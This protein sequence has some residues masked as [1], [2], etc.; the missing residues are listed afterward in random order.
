MWCGHGRQ[1]HLGLGCCMGYSMI[2]GIRGAN[3]CCFRGAFEMARPGPA[4]APSSMCPGEW[5]EGAEGLGL[6]SAH[7]PLCQ[8]VWA[9]AE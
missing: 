9:L 5:E 1:S 4:W 7:G 8:A 2:P 6:R 3:V